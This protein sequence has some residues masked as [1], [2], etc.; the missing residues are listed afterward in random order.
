MKKKFKI[1]IAPDSQ[2]EGHFQIITKVNRDIDVGVIWV[3]DRKDYGTIAHECLHAVQ[4]AT[5]SR[6]LKLSED[7]DEAFAY[8]LGFLV[9][10]IQKA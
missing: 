2:T 7:T 1:E 10:T 4:W 8:L 3:K 9:S 6:G 5:N